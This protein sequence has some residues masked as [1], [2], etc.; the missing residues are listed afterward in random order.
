[1]KDWEPK[2]A[3]EVR[4]SEVRYFILNI[5]MIGHVIRTEMKTKPVMILDETKNR[6]KSTFN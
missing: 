3:L 5:W 2:L 1:M 4:L 6:G